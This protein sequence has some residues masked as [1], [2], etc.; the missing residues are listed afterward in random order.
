MADAPPPDAG[1]REVTHHRRRGR[2]QGRGRGRGRGAPR[3]NARVDFS[4]YH[5]RDAQ[6]AKVAEWLQRAAEEWFDGLCCA[7]ALVCA[8][9]AQEAVYAAWWN[10]LVQQRLEQGLE[11]D[12]AR[13]ALMF[14]SVEHVGALFGGCPWLQF[15]VAAA[16]PWAIVAHFDTD[17][18]PA[19]VPEGCVLANTTVT[20]DAVAA[21]RAGL[22]DAA[23]AFVAEYN[24]TH[25]PAAKADAGKAK[26][27]PAPAP[28]A[29]GT[30]WK[31]MEDEMECDPPTEA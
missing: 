15:V 23:A 17:T 20:T 9:M 19:A 28:P 3:F 22:R 18:G 16:D 26:P 25:P 4:S 2:G 30:W 1:F 8:P 11:V 12:P 6:K 24:A 7:P 5:L 13:S 31:E 14:R 29:E 10:G 21:L 27:V